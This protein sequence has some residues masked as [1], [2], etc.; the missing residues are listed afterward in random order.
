MIII[1]RS[2]TSG[3]AMDSFAEMDNWNSLCAMVESLV[4][5]PG[6]VFYYCIMIHSPCMARSARPA[7]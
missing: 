6:Q 2:I 1:M 4:Y 7:I 5:W 3:H